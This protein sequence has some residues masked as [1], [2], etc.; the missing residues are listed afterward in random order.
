M[1]AA[2]L[3][4]SK[5]RRL[6]PN[7]HH[8]SRTEPFECKTGMVTPGGTTCLL[9]Y[10]CSV[11]ML[12]D[13]PEIRRLPFVGE[14]IARQAAQIPQARR[15]TISSICSALQHEKRHYIFSGCAR[16]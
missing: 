10:A 7:P 5:Q 12:L 8:S 13:A 1:S 14:R 4:D 16:R 2:M 15:C 9:P 11:K 3:D 6:A